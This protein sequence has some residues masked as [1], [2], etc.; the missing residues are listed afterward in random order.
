MSPYFSAEDV[1]NLHNGREEVRSKQDTLKT[2][3]AFRA[4]K[5]ERAREYANQGLCR[6]VDMM[7][8][9]IDVVFELLPPE[10]EEIPD[11]ENTG[12]ATALIQSF[13]INTAGCLDN[14]AWIWVYETGLKNEDGSEYPLH[15][16]GLSGVYWH[17]RRRF[18]KPFRKYLQD[19]KAWFRHI[20]EFR[21]SLAHRIPLYIPPYI[22][23]KESAP[24]YERLGT[25][26][27]KAHD[28]GDY[29]AYDRY[30]QQQQKLGRFLPW[31][32]HSPTE[33][34]PSAVFH[35]QLLQDFVTIDD[36]ANQLLEELDRMAKLPAPVGFR[37]RRRWRPFV[38][39][40]L[41]AL[42]VYALWWIFGG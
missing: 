27:A 2:R 12:G 32:T 33:G 17:L 36:I 26:A 16:V 6:R 4:Y 34:A 5:N 15:L 24:E 7:A 41:A 42:A 10:L 3:F 38:V 20:A 19:R 22:I 25:E 18:T 14:L 13:V 23:S 40:I 8:N 39:A 35:W 1:A 28:R 29:K 9:I 37:S 30:R 11:K 31:M 21:D